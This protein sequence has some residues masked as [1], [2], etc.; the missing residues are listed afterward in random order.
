[1]TVENKQA[2][3]QGYAGDVTVLQAWTLLKDNPD[4]ILV[5]VR[6]NAEWAFVGQPDLS[7][8]NKQVIPISW[9][10]FPNMSPNEN[11][12]SDLKNHHSNQNAP[13]LFLCRSGVRSIAAAISATHAGYEQCY[14]VLAGFEGDLDPNRH[15]GNASGWKNENLAWV[16]G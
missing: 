10:L 14:N 16:Q 8:L 7:S 1:M 12:I 5:D 13:I 15:R 11:F 9:V 6:T 2:G 4:S 3:L